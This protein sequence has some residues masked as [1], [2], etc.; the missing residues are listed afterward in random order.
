[1]KLQTK[2]ANSIGVVL[3]VIALLLIAAWVASLLMG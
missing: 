3:M 2:L 1:M